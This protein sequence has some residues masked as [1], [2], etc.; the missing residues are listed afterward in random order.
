MVMN[1]VRPR[2]KTA[3]LARASSNLPSL[4]QTVVVEHRSVRVNPHQ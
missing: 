4:T 3:V 2:T 1:V